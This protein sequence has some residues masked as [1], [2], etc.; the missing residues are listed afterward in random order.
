MKKT[1]LTTLLL[2]FVGTIGFSQDFDFQEV[3]YANFEDSQ[4]AVNDYSISGTEDGVKTF[5][6]YSI[7]IMFMPIPMFID[8]IKLDGVSFNN[9][10]NIF[11]VGYGITGN[12]DFNKRGLG[13]GVFMYYAFITGK[14]ELKAEDLFLAFKY[15]IRLGGLNS[16]FELSPLVGLGQM[17]FNTDNGNVGKSTYLSGGARVTIRISNRFFCGA[18]IITVPWLFNPEELLSVE[19][20]NEVEIDYKFIAQFN[21]SIRYNIFVDKN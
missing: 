21:L 16:N 4:N 13:F 3:A 17:R 1:I 8:Q 7:G 10:E 19:G 9:D 18:D 14:D 6:E 12:F 15:D 5:R 2:V 20:V 11:G